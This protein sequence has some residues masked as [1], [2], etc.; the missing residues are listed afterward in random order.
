MKNLTCAH[1]LENGNKCGAF[2]MNGSE[3]CF[4][5]DPT[6]AEER[7]IAGQKGGKR[8]RIPSTKVLPE[9]TPDV[10][11]KTIGDVE[12]LISETISQVRRGDLAP[13]VSN[14]ITQLVNSWI[15]IREIGEMEERMRRLEE[16][17]EAGTQPRVLGRL[18]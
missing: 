6:K 11:I 15:K 10:K 18:A 4:F 12:E 14:A 7:R 1:I 16:A 13:N 3:F 2:A 9:D 17:V 5:H 8:S